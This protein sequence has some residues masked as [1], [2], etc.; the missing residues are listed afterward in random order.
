MKHNQGKLAIISSAV[1]M[2]AAGLCHSLLSEWALSSG[3]KAAFS[4]LAAALVALLFL[5]I[6]FPQN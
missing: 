4:G 5:K 6:K 2:S 3:V 1:A